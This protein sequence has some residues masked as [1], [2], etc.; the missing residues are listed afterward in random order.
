MLFRSGENQSD[1]PHREQGAFPSVVKMLPGEWVRYSATADELVQKTLDKEES[2]TEWKDGTL[3]Y[4]D[5]EFQFML[6]NLE[7]IYGK[8][9]VVADSALLHKRVKVGVPYENWKAVKEMMGWMLDIEVVEMD[10]N[11]VRIEKRKEK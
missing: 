4:Q 6:E 8:S 7:D 10:E 1:I 5:V 11:Q 9:F 2:V 3:S